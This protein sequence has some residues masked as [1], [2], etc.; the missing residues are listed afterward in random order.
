[1]AAGLE[2]VMFSARDVM[3]MGHASDQ[4]SDCEVLK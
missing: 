1:M 3:T 2:K 4:V